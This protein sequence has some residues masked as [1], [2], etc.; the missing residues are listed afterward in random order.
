MIGVDILSC[1]CTLEKH[2]TVMNR[3][4]YQFDEDVI[5]RVEHLATE[6][7]VLVMTD[8]YPMF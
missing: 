1:H 7:K 8:G 6:Q 2:Y 4:Y 3:K 5:G